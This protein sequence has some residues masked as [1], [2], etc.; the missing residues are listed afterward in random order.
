MRQSVA[1]NGGIVANE[2]NN[3]FCSTLLAQNARQLES[4]QWRGGQRARRRTS[5][6]TGR[7]LQTGLPPVY[8]VVMAR[9]ESK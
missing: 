4:N 9:M 7:P 5:M 8:F 6:R 3:G 1:N 2:C